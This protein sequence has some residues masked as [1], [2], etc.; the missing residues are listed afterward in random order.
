MVSLVS[1]SVSTDCPAKRPAD[2]TSTTRPST[3]AVVGIAVWS[4]I[5]T[6]AEIDPWNT[7]P[8]CAFSESTSSFSRMLSCVPA[9]TV[10]FCGTAGGGGVDGVLETE[11]LLLPLLLSAGTVVRKPLSPLLLADALDDE[12]ELRVRVLGE[13]RRASLTGGGGLK[14]D[15]FCGC[16]FWSAA[17]AGATSRL[18]TTVLTP[19]TCAASLAAALRAASLATVPVS[20]TTPLFALIL[21]C[22]S[23][24]LLSPLILFCT[25]EATCAS[26]RVPMR[27][28]PTANSAREIRTTQRFLFM[29]ITPLVF[30]WR[31]RELDA[32]QL[33]STASKCKIL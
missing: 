2:F 32:E 13:G 17:E 33:E 30:W 12:R 23:G 20:V 14:F 8:T 26:G 11:S 16:A 29:T 15:W 24:I 25:S 21:S 6:G 5:E 19:S 27:E 3:S 28:Q 22:L 1:S 4:S 7:S 9:G 31:M 10:I 18:F